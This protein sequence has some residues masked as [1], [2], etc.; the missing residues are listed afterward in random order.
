MVIRPYLHRSRQLFVQ[1]RQFAKKW[2]NPEVKESRG[3]IQLPGRIL[4]E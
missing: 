1:L 2:L 4:N 3:A